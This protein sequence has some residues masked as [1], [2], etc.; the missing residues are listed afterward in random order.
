MLVNGFQLLT[1]VV[2]LTILDFL[3]VAETLLNDSEIR[4]ILLLT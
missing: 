4:L 3:E 2:K 1:I